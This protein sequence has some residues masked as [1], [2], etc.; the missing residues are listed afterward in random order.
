VTGSLRHLPWEAFDAGRPPWCPPGSPALVDDESGALVSVAAYEA[1]EA[2][3]AAVAALRGA[4]AA[5]G[6]FAVLVGDAVREAAL[7]TAETFR[8]LLEAFVREAGADDH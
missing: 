4:V 3:A 8:P 7:S 5:Y 6:R 2:A 1:S